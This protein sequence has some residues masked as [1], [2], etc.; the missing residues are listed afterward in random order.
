MAI[1]TKTT[2]SL[3]ANVVSVAICL[4]YEILTQSAIAQ[5]DVEKWSRYLCHFV[6]QYDG[7]GSA[8]THAPS[9]LSMTVGVN[10]IITP[11]AV[12]YNNDG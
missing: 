4:I 9:V 2:T 1:C 10:E 6:A 11:P 5:Y 8:D 3:R 7:E 12:A